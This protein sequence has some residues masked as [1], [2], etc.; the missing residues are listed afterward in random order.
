[1]KIIDCIQGTD[2]WK[3]I[4]KGM[5]T[6]TKL[7][8]VVSAPTTATYKTLMLELV[9]EELWPV[10]EIFKNDAMIRWTMLEPIAREKYEQMTNQKVDEVGFCIHDTR[11]YCWL[12]PDWFIKNKQGEYTKAL[13]IKCPGTKNHLKYILEDRIPPEYKW[14]I[15]N[16]FL[17]N[18]KL[19]ELDFMTFNPDI[20]LPH[21]QTHII[22]IKRADVQDD[23]KALEPKLDQYAKLW[24]ELI[25]KL[26]KNEKTLTQ[27]S[28]SSEQ[29]TKKVTKT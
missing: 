5:V 17:V 19:E 16:Y 15:V 10:P 12:S 26:T 6:G 25:N 13:E 18:E 28:K 14:Q 21:L 24:E 4:R 9:A 23:L 1:M 27:K 20:Y 22:T 29:N 3:Q 7:K 2:E 8:W 11:K